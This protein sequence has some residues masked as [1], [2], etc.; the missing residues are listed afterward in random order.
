MKKLVLRTLQVL[1]GIYILHSCSSIFGPDY[2]EEGPPFFFIVSFLNAPNNHQGYDS[3]YSADVIYAGKDS[4]QYYF[5]DPALNDTLTLRLFG[6]EETLPLKADSLYHLTYEIIGGWPSTYGLIIRQ[7]NTV[8]FA[9]ISDWEL[10]KRSTLYD[11]TGINVSINKVLTDRTHTTKT[12]RKKLTNLELK[13]AHG[14]E[15]IFLRQGEAA[16]LGDWHIYLRVAREVEYM[17]NCLDDGV[18]GVS[19]TILR[20]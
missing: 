10:K 17:S 6:V 5:S 3:P 1:A 8:L 13:F 14:S 4:V 7:N 18:N 11:S 19:F 20:R 9:G 15:A 2:L 16:S 12:C